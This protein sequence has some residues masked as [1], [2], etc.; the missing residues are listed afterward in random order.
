[1]VVSENY[2]GDSSLPFSR[3]FVIP[4]P[5]DEGALSG[6]HRALLLRVNGQSARIGARDLAFPIEKQ[7]QGPSG[8]L[9]R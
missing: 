9:T 8:L 5:V 4:S 7:A 2:A 3:M 1:M 6:P